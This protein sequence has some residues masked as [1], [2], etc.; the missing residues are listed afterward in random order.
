M[1]GAPMVCLVWALPI[2]YSTTP[3]RDAMGCDEYHPISKKGSN[4]TEAGGIGYTVVDAL[5]TIMMMG[6]DEE[7]VR[8]RKWVDEKLDFEKDG[9]FN[10]FE[11]RLN[12]G[13]QSCIHLVQTTIRV[14][15][16]LLSAYHLSGGDK[17][18]LDRAVDVADRIMYTFDTP[19]GLPLPM[20]NLA[21]RVGIP[22]R[23]YPHLVSTAEVSTLQLELRY[24]SIL[25]GED[26]YWD[27]AENVQPSSPAST[28]STN[29]RRRS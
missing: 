11:V 26:S 20:I 22:D 2:L 12:H 1:R 5:D 4:L 28:S 19:S 15:G 23:D 16:G 10:T 3:E 21:K 24:L 17:L 18:Y 7:Y 14:L 29:P 25:T 27:K 13:S 9:Q 6:L 8:A